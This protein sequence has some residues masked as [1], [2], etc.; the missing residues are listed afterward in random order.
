M[1]TTPTLPNRRAFL[2]FCGCLALAYLIPFHARPYTGFYNEW[3]AAFAFTILAAY[4]AARLPDYRLP[5]IALAPLALA[6]VIALQMALG[7]LTMPADAVLPFGSLLVCVLA[8]VLG[9]SIAAQPSGSYK[10]T[11]A[12]AYAMVGASLVSLVIACLQFAGLE[13]A[14]DPFMVNMTYP[15]ESIIRPFANLAQP[16]QLALLFCFAIAA[17]WWLFQARLMPA[18]PALILT[19]GFLWGLAL[20]QSR[21]LWLVLPLL[22]VVTTLWQFT[23]NYRRHPKWL[24]AALLALYVG[25]VFL[26]PVLAA[27]MMP[28]A[29]DVR[30]GTGSQRMYLYGLAWNVSLTHPWLGAG[31]GEYLV[32]QIAWSATSATRVYSSHAHNLILNLAAEIGW[33]LAL[34]FCAGVGYWLLRVWRAKPLSTESALALLCLLMAGVHSMLEFPLW[35]AY[36]LVPLALMIGVLHQEQLGGRA[37]RLPRTVPAVIVLLLAA[38]LL[39]IAMDLR[40]VINGYLYLSVQE[41][42]GPLGAPVTV[43]PEWTLFPQHFDYLLASR[44]EIDEGMSPADIAQLE[45]VAFRFG[46]EPALL[47]MVLAYAMNGRDQDALRTMRIIRNLHPDFYPEA[48]ARWEVLARKSP[49]KYQELFEQM[50][51]PKVR[52]ETMPKT[53]SLRASGVGHQTE[54]GREAGVN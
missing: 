5:W 2:L 17:L 54:G 30:L 29:A 33:P 13:K 38:S 15:K 12:L 3:L 39:V 46:N 9:A 52:P 43:R 8:I 7:L 24:P 31:W 25:F 10:L 37:L 28:V 23:G 16:N 53:P 47:R 51:E 6:A 11:K 34:A 21:M 41:I 42:A 18:T 4:G 14:F 48:Y 36:V 22:A 40:R 44:L 26:V 50:P 20:T 19:V 32:Q 1:A 45:A 27:L 35:Y 49:E